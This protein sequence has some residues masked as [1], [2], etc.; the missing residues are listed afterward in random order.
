MNDKN[1]L[2]EPLNPTE[3]AHLQGPD[4]EIDKINVESGED[5]IHN[6]SRK[7]SSNTN[8]DINSNVQAS[9][10]EGKLVTPDSDPR[11]R[12]VFTPEDRKLGGHPPLITIL[13][14]SVGP[15]LSQVTNALYGIITTI[16]ISK[17]C[18]EDGLSAVSMMNAFDGIGRAFGFFLA[19]A[20]A[21]QI[22]FLYG[23]GAS[24]EAGQII[25]DLI[26][27]SFVCGAITAGTLIPILRPITR[28]FGADD[29]IIQLGID[30]MLPLNICAFNSCLF[31]A[32]GGFLQGEGRTFLFGMSNVTCLCLNMA[33]LDPIFLFVF[34]MGIRGASI[35]TVFSELIP[36]MTI[37]VLF[38]C[39][40]FG[41]KPE[42]NQLLKKFSPNTWPALK[43]GFSSL[44]AQLSGCIP[45]IVVRKYMGL[46][47]GDDPQ[48]FADVMAGFNAAIRLG[49]LTWS[50]F[51]AISQAFI[52]AASYA[53]AAKRY[54]R[55]LMLSF[56]M[57]WLM[58]VWGT[59]TAILTWTIPR[60]LSMMFSKDE[61][62]LKYAERMV[63]Y[64]NAVGPLL[65]GKIVSQSILQS[66]QMG[67]RAT[68]LSFIN[69]FVF[70]ILF[71]YVLYYTDKNDGARIIWCYPLSYVASC[72]L[73]PFFLWGPLKKIF[74]SMREE[75]AEFEFEN[76]NEEVELDDLKNNSAAKSRETDALNEKH[77]GFEEKN[78]SLNESFSVSSE[79]IKNDDKNGEAKKDEEVENDDNDKE[80]TSNVPEI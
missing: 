75:D 48:D 31:I 3:E 13:R 27:M 25:A 26:R 7:G 67:P 78:E 73:S 69:N 49:N 36:G 74:K 79:V 30:Y 21:T 35:A 45:S 22:S 2:E 62:Y 58:L 1:S 39:H 41:V 20:A 9:E 17:A 15:L 65:G 5:N 10:S 68:V 63:A 29:H 51:G 42:L 72:L 77:D 55:Y 57:I 59:F 19:I 12:R 53:Y 44:I 4:V 64:N 11:P 66:L 76:M 16:W 32:A 47:A 80:E 14:L 37:V 24:Q 60:Q 43:V 46:G 56:H 71:N 6:L 18:G 52:P 34:K 40:K 54:R 23:K 33:I 61:R 50:I 38:Y 28:W 70:I 8:I